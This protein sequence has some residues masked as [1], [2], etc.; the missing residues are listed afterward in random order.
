M[1]FKVEGLVLEVVV[2]FS[3]VVV[4]F[5]LFEVFVCRFFVLVGKGRV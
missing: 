5:F 2:F 3:G 1:G 4:V